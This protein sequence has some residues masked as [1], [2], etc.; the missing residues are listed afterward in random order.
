M[1]VRQLFIIVSLELT[2]NETF[3]LQSVLAS[4]TGHVAIVEHLIGLPI[5][6]REDKIAAL[7][8]LGATYVDKKRDMVNA[9]QFWRRSMEERYVDLKKRS[10]VVAVFFRIAFLSFNSLC[11]FFFFF[12]S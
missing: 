1:L 9:L 3:T 5:V 8:L 7:E 11:A 2:H 10:R 6:S 4:V 12:S